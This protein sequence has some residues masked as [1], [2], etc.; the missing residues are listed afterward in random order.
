[1]VIAHPVCK[2]LTNSGVCHLYTGRRKE[3]GP[4]LPRWEQ[5]KAGAEFFN[6]FLDLPHVKKVVVEN[7]IMHKY[8]RELIKFPYTQIIQPYMFGHME[9]KATCLWLKGV[10]KLEETNNVYVEMMKLPD[11]QRQRLHYLPPGPNRERDRSATF[12]GIADAF[13]EKWG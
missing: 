11:N 1:M 10:D 3:N 7:P 9:Q 2:Y 8:A 6:I 12:P 13:A 4:Y 5:M